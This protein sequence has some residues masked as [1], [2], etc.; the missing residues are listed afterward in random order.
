MRILWI[1]LAPI[2]PAARILEKTK[3]G[4]S[5]TW[6]QTAYESMQD[7]SDLHFG[8]LVSDRS[9]KNGQIVKKESNEGKAYAL[10]Y[11]PFSS[12]G[13]EL[14]EKIKSAIKEVIADFKP[15]IIHIWGTESNFTAGAALLTDNIPTVIFIQGLVGIHSRYNSPHYY[16]EVNKI[17]SPKNQILS[18]LKRYYFKR[19]I[20]FE[21]K[22]IRKVKN[23]ITDNE[24][25][26]AYVKSFC[27]KCRFHNYF[28]AP[29]NIFFEQV[30]DN[31]NIEEHSIF[32]VYCSTQLKGLSKLLLAMSILKKKY[33]D[34]KL[35]IP[36]PFEIDENGHLKNRQSSN[37][38]KW[39]HNYINTNDLTDNI[40][41][42]GQQNAAGMAK[43]LSKVSAFI[44]PSAM[45]VH[46][47]S[48]REA[49]AVGTPV[50]SSVCGSICEFV[51]NG[52]NGLIYRF[53]EPEVLAYQVSKLFDEKDFARNIGE[54]GR[55]TLLEW[56]DNDQKSD[57][58]LLKIYCSLL[59]N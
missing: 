8:F 36:G 9:L 27:D 10:G 14:P 57:S 50:V 37:F 11:A 49:M 52:E 35:Y 58:S 18:R 41:F 25:T 29:N 47:S 3:S 4:S 54:N 19:H 6:I 22:A 15:D 48:M 43:Y 28:L 51:R 2:G 26:K 39:C 44:S 12:F 7:N 42:I 45:E 46:S 13:L 33:T 23:I 56:R 30:R 40:K 38:M 20:K 34:I 17:A 16:S 32:T 5:G 31:D 55:K 1:S 21:Q 59:R 53:D 24:F